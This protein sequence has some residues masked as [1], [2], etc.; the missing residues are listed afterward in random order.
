MTTSDMKA[1]GLR[2]EISSRTSGACVWSGDAF[3]AKDA[4][5]RM[6]SDAGYADHAAA[7]ETTG[8]TTDIE[9]ASDGVWTCGDLTISTVS[10][11]I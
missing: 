6:S 5:D 3:G 4:L 9:W 7:C 11:E 2:F 10:V 8:D 1:H